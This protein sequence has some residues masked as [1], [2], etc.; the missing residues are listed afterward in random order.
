[1]CGNLKIKLLI[2]VLYYFIIFK[3][4]LSFEKFNYFYKSKVYL[5]LFLFI[6]LIIFY[7]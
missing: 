5:D 4:N 1:M 2:E 7:F 6:V 3:K